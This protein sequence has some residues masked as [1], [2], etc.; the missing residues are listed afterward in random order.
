[1]YIHEVCIWCTDC[2]LYTH[3]AATSPSYYAVNLI[4]INR[5]QLVPTFTHAH[6]RTLAAAIR[7]CQKIRTDSTTFQPRVG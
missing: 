6:T 2:M 7:K 5:T 4:E 3:A 1:M